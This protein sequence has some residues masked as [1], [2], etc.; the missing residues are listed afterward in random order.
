[1]LNNIK[2]KICIAI[3][4]FLIVLVPEIAAAKKVKK[5]WS[6][7]R[8]ED[9]ITGQKSCIVTAY[10]QFGKTK[11]SRNGFLYPIVEKNDDYGVLV[12]V[13]SGGK[14]RLPSGTILWRVDDF[15]HRVIDP[16]DNPNL[17]TDSYA[18]MVPQVSSGNS[19]VDAQVAESMKNAFA[20]TA[21]ITA[22]STLAHGER[23]QEIIEEMLIG[24]GLV[25]RSKQ[26]AQSVGLPSQSKYAVG[27]MTTKGR[28]PIPLDESFADGLIECGITLNSE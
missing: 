2:C 17:E 23:A 5:A 9:P 12:G 3:S 24:K 28:K 27:Q 4:V 6:V 25:F 7:T 19:E 1:M 18:A 26:S 21:S 15:P 10:D 11:F 22:T 13:S 8:T 16:K 20:V 14:Y